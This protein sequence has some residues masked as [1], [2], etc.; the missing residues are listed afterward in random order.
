MTATRYEIQTKQR[1]GKW[2]GWCERDSFD[3]IKAEWQ[4]M[5]G[6]RRRARCR[7]I[8][9]T[10]VAKVLAT[11]EPPRPRTGLPRSVAPA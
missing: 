3:D 1:G 4:R 9:S 11:Y 7:R 5:P 2:V 10:G 8:E 6:V